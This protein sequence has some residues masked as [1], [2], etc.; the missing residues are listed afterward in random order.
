MTCIGERPCW[1]KPQQKNKE[2]N[3][4]G[5]EIRS[6]LLILDLTDLDISK[7]IQTRLLS[8]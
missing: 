6:S 2:E 7:T 5:G 3:Y 4:E 8:Y 1:P